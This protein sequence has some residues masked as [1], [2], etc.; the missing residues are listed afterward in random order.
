MDESEG[1]VLEVSAGVGGQE[2][3]LFSEEL[4]HM[5]TSF[6]AY[7][8]WDFTTLSYADT[9]LGYAINLT[10]IVWLLANV[11]DF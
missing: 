4:F 8:G 9:E 6:A 5:Y 3:M 7:N 2:A 10:N 1:L 11:C